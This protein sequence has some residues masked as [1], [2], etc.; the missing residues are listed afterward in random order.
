MKCLYSVESFLGRLITNCYPS[1]CMLFIDLAA[2]SLAVNNGAVQSSFAQTS[3]Y[4]CSSCTAG[5]NH[6]TA[7]NTAI[8][9]T[10]NTSRSH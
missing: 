8:N 10:S 3:Y 2:L 9:T 6:S 1:A 7:S 5:Q 4:S